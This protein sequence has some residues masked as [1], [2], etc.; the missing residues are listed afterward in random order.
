MVEPYMQE[1]AEIYGRN[2]WHWMVDT[3]IGQIHV[4]QYERHTERDL[5]SKLFYYDNQGA[6]R[7]FRKWCKD[8]LEGRK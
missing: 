4:V 1:H 2:V 7:L 6:E 8:I 5:A 3:T